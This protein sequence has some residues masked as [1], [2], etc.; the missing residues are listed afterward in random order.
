MSIKI[1]G[2]LFFKIKLNDQIL[3][4]IIICIYDLLAKHITTLAS[5][6][7]NQISIY[8]EIKSLIF[9]CVNKRYLSLENPTII[10]K[11]FI[12][13]CISILIISGI[14]QN[15]EKCIE[16]LISDA[17]NNTPE[18]IYICLKSIADCDLIMNF[19]KNEDE[20]DNDSWKS[21]ELNLQEQ[22][23]FEIKEKLKKETG[24]IF[25]FIYKVYKNI[26]TYEKNLRFRIIKSII[27]LFIFW[28]Q[29]DLNIL[30]NDSISKIIIELTTQTIIE[31]NF[32]NIEILKRVAE[33]L[34]IAVTF[35]KNV[36]LYEF[37]GKI[38]D[39]FS[40]EETLKNIDENVNYEEK[41]GIEK[42]L[43]FIL[44][45]LEQYKRNNNKNKDILWNL[46]KI[47]SSI[48]ENFIFF[49]FDL[50][51]ERNI[52]VFQWIKNLISERKIISWMFFSTIEVMMNFITDYFRFYTYNE[53]QKKYF[54]E[55]FIDIMLNIMNN[56]CYNKIN[57]ND[58]S[59][60]QKEILFLNNEANWN[61]N[62]NYI[63]RDG[64]EFYL[65]DI[66]TTEYRNSAENVFYS[67]GLIFKYGFNSREYELIPFLKL[68]S[69]IEVNNN[70]SNAS[71]L[72]LSDKNIVILDTI[73]FLLKSLNKTID[74][75]SSQ[76]TIRLIN[77]Y[78]YNLL[79]SSYINNVQIYIDYLLILNQFS[80]FI[81]KDEKF[82]NIISNL[83]LVTQ[84]INN[85]QL[86]LDSCYVVICNLFRDFNKN[87]FYKEYCQAFLQR[88]KILCNNYSL[89]NISQMEN[90]IKSIFF[91]LGINDNIEYNNDN[92]SANG[93]N[94]N[95]LI[96]LFEEILKPLLLINLNDKIKDISTLKKFIIKSY[97]ISKEI[98][99]NISLCN[100]NIRKYMLNYFISNTIDN[101]IELN[102]DSKS[103]NNIK[104][105]NLFQNDEEISNSI[106]D[107]YEKNASNIVEDC[108]HLIPKINEIFIELFKLNNDY[109]QIIDFFGLFYKYILQNN[110]KEDNNYID[111]NKYVLDNFL[112]IIKLSINYL[113]SKQKVDEET[114]KRINLLLS[115]IIEVFPNIYV[116]E[117]SN[118]FNDLITIIKFV[119]NFI[120]FIINEKRED[121]YDRFISNIIK[122]LSSILNNNIIKIIS[123]FIQQEQKKEL[124][125]NI[126]YKTSKLLYLK[127]FK[128]LSIEALLL[129]YYQ[130]II[131]EPNLYI[132]LFS[133][134]LISTKMFDEMYI[135]N[136]NKYLQLYYQNKS[137]IIDFIRDI[138]YII[139]N[140][141]EN[142]CL[143]FYFNR[144]NTKKSLN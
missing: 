91:C 79:N 11:N 124:I 40:I 69:I 112:L 13:D 70:N 64:D 44:N 81:I 51:N 72:D 84:N 10:M 102:K 113:N 144:L 121:C 107:F 85:N 137:D 21:S 109:F 43:D 74:N 47:F 30:T 56:C 59:Q 126:L 73:L 136:I 7:E 132:F 15:W 24:K 88:Y 82:K 92:N 4:H 23:R 129:L 60:L 46:A 93:V 127:E 106:F 98:F 65:N 34:N 123:N 3:D 134:L 116:R 138:I 50:N 100:Q 2:S 32:N 37:Y 9:Q 52:L 142:D 1:F 140:K 114:F 133:Q 14:S 105:F 86:L 38:D 12:C 17:Q 41:I 111:V 99:Y 42:W 25:E 45:Q 62:N 27:D 115:N 101:L 28:T 143:L 66:D 54:Q 39:G 16:E 130:M 125:M 58:F 18:L 119:F 20:N 26:N 35:S 118:L 97:T 94:D 8:N 68:F 104:I 19:M 139:L 103:Q 135:N 95:D 122:C 75:E 22:K 131:F 117:I 90:L 87:I 83:L 71:Q 141:K 6:E 120:E 63:N 78:I 128:N 57:Q 53:Q 33:L 36:R 61:E 5:V 31:E 110:K 29:L 49:F 80:S 108:P 55:Y 96:L 67:I 77:D 76:D 48:T 89:N